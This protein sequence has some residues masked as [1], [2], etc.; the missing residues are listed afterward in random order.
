MLEPMNKNKMYT[1]ID[2][3]R[4]YSG[5]MPE[6]EMHELE[7]SALEDPFLADALDGYVHAS[8]AEK[9]IIGLKEKIK[10]QILSK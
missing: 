4:Y 1:A 8:S 7:R 6:S 5:L 3:Q 10:D 9:D 2:F